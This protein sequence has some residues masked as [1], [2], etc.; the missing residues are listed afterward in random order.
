MDYRERDQQFKINRLAQDLKELTISITPKIAPKN[1]SK[2]CEKIT[3]KIA[4]KN[5]H[6]NQSKNEQD[7]DNCMGA[8]SLRNNANSKLET[9][10]ANLL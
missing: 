7:F 9:L 6:K 1:L 2:N 3:T 5:L 4:Q 8:A 10:K